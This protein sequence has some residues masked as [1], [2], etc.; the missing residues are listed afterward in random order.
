MLPDS[1][2]RTR[3][4]AR[5]ASAGRPARSRAVAWTT[6]P[7]VQK[8]HWNAPRSANAARRSADSS[9]R[10]SAVVTSPS[11]SS[12]GVA[13]DSRGRPATS[14][15]QAPHSPRSHASL[16]DVAPNRSR[17]TAA[18]T[19]PGGAAASPVSPLTVMFMKD[20]AGRDGWTGPAAATPGRPR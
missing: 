5:S 9:A 10:P 8:P 14:T 12:T 19:V 18:R 6:C 16:T 15:V 20:L 3:A 7:G 17:R 2:A 4:R 13:Q 11:T 1:S